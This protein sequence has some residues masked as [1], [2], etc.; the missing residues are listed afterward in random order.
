MGRPRDHL[1]K[2]ILSEREEGGV[3]LVPALGGQARR[4]APEG[5]RPKFSADGNWMEYW[6]GDLDW[7]SLMGGKTYVVAAAGGVPRQ[8]RANFNAAWRWQP[9]GLPS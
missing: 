9:S 1:K 8:V 7:R 2:S 6:V 3:Y 4:I 5:R